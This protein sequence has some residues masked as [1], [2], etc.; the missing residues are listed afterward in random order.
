MVIRAFAR[1]SPAQT[2][3]TDSAREKETGAAGCMLR[4]FVGIDEG[5]SARGFSRPSTPSGALAANDIFT[6]LE[7]WCIHAAEETREAKRFSFS[8]GFGHFVPGLRGRM[9][10]FSTAS[11]YYSQIYKLLALCRRDR[12][13]KY[14]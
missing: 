12:R 14:S 11:S 1:P 2:K 13:G 6:I 4:N 10:R 7:G 3:R 8:F 9:S 5:G